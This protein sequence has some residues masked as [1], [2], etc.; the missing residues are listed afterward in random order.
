MSYFTVAER[1]FKAESLF[2]ECIDILNKKGQ[3]YSNCDFANSNFY[4]VG[5]VLACGKYTVWGVYFYK[6]I[7]AIMNFIGK[8]KLESEPIRERIKDAI[9]YLAILATM[10]EEGSPNDNENANDPSS[11]INK[12]VIKNESPAAVASEHL[13]FG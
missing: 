7:C 13:R 10:I 12:N 3:D 5:Q 4:E 2:S 9:N 6:H 1:S 11:E 8:G